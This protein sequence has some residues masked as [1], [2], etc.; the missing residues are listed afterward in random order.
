[1]DRMLYLGMTGAKHVVMA[2]T[3]NANN[4]ANVSTAG[5]RADFHT[6]LDESVPGFGYPTRAN[7]ISGGR[8]SNLMSGPIRSTGRPLD[9][10]VNGDAW[11]A[12]VAPD[13]G[14]AYSRR[15]DFHITANGQLLNGA[16]QQVLGE[17][18][19]VALPEHQ[20][21]SIGEDGTVSVVPLGQG[22]ETLVVVDRIKLVALDAERVEKGDDGLM[23]HRDGSPGVITAESRLMSGHLE[24]SNLNAVEAMVNM[25]NLSRQYEMQVKVMST[26]RE[27]ADASGR[28]LRLE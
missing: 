27:I 26:A 4:L 18:G 28:L 3:T 2:Q 9:V 1:M 16:G 22:P 6:L 5:F 15:G 12:V 11:L 14:E 17:G 21:V 24:A 10:T 7:A 19:P 13:G 23:R 20:S 8:D 25:I